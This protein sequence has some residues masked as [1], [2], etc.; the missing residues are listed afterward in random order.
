M[1]RL[2]LG[3]FGSIHPNEPRQRP[4]R[5]P[6]S[7][8]TLHGQALSLQLR[9]VIERGRRYGN[10]AYGAA[11]QAVVDYSA[12]LAPVWAEVD[13]LI[14]PVITGPAPAGLNNTG[15]LP[16]SRCRLRWIPD[17]DT[18]DGVVPGSKLLGDKPHQSSRQHYPGGVDL[19]P[20]HRDRPQH[21][22]YHR[23]PIHQGGLAQGKQHRRH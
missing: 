23:H 19:Q 5:S 14:T 7:W 22:Q 20:K 16:I 15:S 11:R 3:F 8:A 10:L 9:Q 18:P 4:P 17:T 12:A 6:N 13:A 21:R 1:H 2:N